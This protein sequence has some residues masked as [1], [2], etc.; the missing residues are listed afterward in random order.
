MQN[1]PDFI[2]SSTFMNRECDTLIS[3]IERLEM[4]RGMQEIRREDVIKQVG[5]LN[6]AVAQF[7][8]HSLNNAS[9]P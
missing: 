5:F 3:E 2:E 7:V 4:F 6:I 9:R 1:H 8:S